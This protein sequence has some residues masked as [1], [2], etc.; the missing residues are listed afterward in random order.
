MKKIFIW[1]ILILT[2]SINIYLVFFWQPEGKRTTQENSSKEVISYDKNLYRID[3]NEI[4]EKLSSDDKRNLEKITKKLSTL[5]IRKI[6]GYFE[7]SNDEKGLINTFVLLKKRLS[8]DDYK[9]IEEISNSF[10]DVDK[11]NKEIKNKKN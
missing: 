2:V 3:K 4:L 1:L 8:S 10:L 5:D 9:K 11:I 7:D 6:K